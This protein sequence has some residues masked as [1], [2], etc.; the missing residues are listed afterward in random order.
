MLSASV[1]VEGK[2]VGAIDRGLMCL[3]GVCRSDTLDDAR[4]IANKILGTKFFPPTAPDGS[5]STCENWKANVQQVAGQL[6]LVSQFTLFAICKVASSPRMMVV[7]WV[8][9]D[10]VVYYA[11]CAGNKA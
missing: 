2:V 5:I 1:T 11:V 9:A 7:S 8:C 10:D 3:V 4:W 6:L